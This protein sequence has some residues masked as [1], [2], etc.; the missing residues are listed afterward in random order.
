MTTKGDYDY[1]FHED[2][3]GGY[4]FFGS[5]ASGSNDLQYINYSYYYRTKNLLPSVVIKALKE[6]RRY[7]TMSDKLRLITINAPSKMMV[8]I[9]NH[10]RNIDTKPKQIK[11]DL[12]IFEFVRNDIEKAKLENQNLGGVDLLKPLWGAQGAT[13]VDGTVFEEF[14]N[15]ID[16]MRKEGK[17]KVG[18][19]PSLVIVEGEKA[20]VES[21]WKGR[22]RVEYGVNNLT[23]QLIAMEEKALQ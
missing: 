23:T 13:V 11:L 21:G 14:S 9:L 12:N 16:L 6:Y 22:S 1:K 8:N 18:A 10:L 4:Y 20:N 2:D 15:F 17:V 5:S 19:N 7:Y 3:E